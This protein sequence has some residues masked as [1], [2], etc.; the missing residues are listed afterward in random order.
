MKNKFLKSTLILIVGGFFTKIIGLLIRIVITRIIGPLGMGL[1]SM[2]MPTFMILITLAQLG[3][4][5]ALNVL[6]GENKHNNRNLVL[7]ATLMSLI[8]DFLI[9]VVLIFFSDTMA[10]TFLH[11][12]RVK[13]GLLSIGFVLPFIT[14]SNML[15]SYFFG[16][17]KVV[18]HVLTNIIE[19]II[20]LILIY[21]FLPYFLSKGI[22]IAIGFIILTNIFSEL[23]S[24]II[25]LVLLPNRKLYK[26]DFAYNQN[27]TK[28]LLNISIPITGSRIISNMGYFF[29]PI[30]ISFVL[31]KVGYDNDFI[32]REYGIIN[33]FVMQ[34]VLLPSFF[35]SAISQAL[36]PII[37][38]MYVRKDFYGIKRKLKQAI[39]ITLS[40]GIAATIIFEICP[41]VILKL[42][43]KTTYGVSYIKFI[44]PICLFHYIQAP[45]SACLQAMSK[46]KECMKGTI[47]GT[48]IR[49]TALFSLSFLKIGMWSLLIATG[50]SIILVTAYY[51][52]VI[53][54]IL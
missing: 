18:P 19:D 13:L 26:K 39:F 27:N 40:I 41:E 21:K 36:I 30:I 49:T 33:G 16:K 48:V 50:V 44:A 54:K 7:S 12:S 38:N 53:K 1:Y 15:R 23:S 17:M 6:V 4:P 43:F 25:F 37:S 29:E 2:I 47:V 10:A 52:T 3:L 22:E 28:S 35:S 45:I 32:V 14:I 31:L 20:R 11:E 5:N 9:I 8:I 51:F 46:A 24:I 42:I 34:L